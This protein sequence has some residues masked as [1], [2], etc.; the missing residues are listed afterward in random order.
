MRRQDS[1]AFKSWDPF[2]YFNVFVVSASGMSIE[3]G[4]DLFNSES[5]GRTSAH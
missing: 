1:C 2:S 4:L 5:V 3:V